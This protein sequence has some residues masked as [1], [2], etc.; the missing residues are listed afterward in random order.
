MVHSV[1]TPI[2]IPSAPSLAFY[3][4]FPGLPGIVLGP[5]KY[6]TRSS[7]REVRIRVLLGDLDKQIPESQTVFF[8]PQN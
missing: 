4:T 3:Q 5:V 2:G 8:A 6:I 1:P 7:G